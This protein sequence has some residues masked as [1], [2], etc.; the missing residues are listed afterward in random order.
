MNGI[1]LLAFGPSLAHYSTSSDEHFKLLQRVG[2]EWHRGKFVLDAH[3][4]TDGIIMVS[5]GCCVVYCGAEG[6]VDTQ[7]GYLLTSYFSYN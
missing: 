4:V 2:D 7:V 5:C 6:E 3:C 1:L